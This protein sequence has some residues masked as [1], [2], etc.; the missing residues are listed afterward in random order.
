VCGC[1]MCVIPRSVRREDLGNKSGALV[2]WA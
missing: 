2:V 1:N